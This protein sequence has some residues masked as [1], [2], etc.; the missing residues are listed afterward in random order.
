M[1]PL[2]LSLRSRPAQRIDLA[3]LTAVPLAGK[4][5]S[6]VAA[7]E[8]WSGNRCLRLGDA[9]DLS[10][11]PGSELEIRNSCD[12]LDRLGA[13]MAGGRLIVKGD[14]GAFLGAGLTGGS[15]VLQGN[16]GAWVG[17]G[18]TGGLIQVSGNVGDFVAA[19]I[20]GDH[21]GMKGGAIVVGGDAGDRAGDRMRRGNVL[22]EGSAG[23]YCAS[24]MVAGTIAVWGSVGRSPGLAMRRGT[25]LL[26]QAPDAVLPT[27]NDCGEY[28]L[29]FLALLARSWR[30]L[31]GRFAGL[32]DRGFLVR[33]YMGDLANGGRG[34]ILVRQ[35]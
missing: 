9:F 7:I 25:L 28:P 26:R 16:A 2:V 24:R 19:A 21:Q 15:I 30:R 12:Q 34:E 13:G 17:T 27:F 29:N 18:M 20:P 33:R 4:P 5:L 23:D 22:I 3:P 6:A 1:S 31:P 14:A 8:L 11:D 35:D 32:P 10:G